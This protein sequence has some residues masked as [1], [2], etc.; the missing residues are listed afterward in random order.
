LILQSER[1][2]DQKLHQQHLHHHL[3]QLLY[4]LEHQMVQS[5]HQDFLVGDLR[6]EYYLLHQLHNKQRHHHQILLLMQE[7]VLFVLHHLHHQQMLL[8][9]KLKLLLD[10]LQYDCNHQVHLLLHHQQL[11]ENLLL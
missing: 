9:K 3:R 7:L 11:L 2:L 5:I 4:Y 6:M 10:Y 1:F 8:L